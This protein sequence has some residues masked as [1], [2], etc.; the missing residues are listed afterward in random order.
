MSAWWLAEISAGGNVWRFTDGPPVVVEDSR[1]DAHR[2]ASGLGPLTLAQGET[3]VDIEF[4]RTDEILVDELEL[5][6]VVVSRWQEGTALET[7]TVFVRGRARG[8][9]YGRVGELVTLGV[10]TVAPG[11]EAPV[12]VESK[13]TDASTWPLTGSGGTL[14]QE[15]AGVPYPLLF[16]YPGYDGSAT[17]RAVVPVALAQFV[18]ATAAS[19]YAV[20]SDRNVAALTRAYLVDFAPDTPVRGWQT[21]SSI[22]DEL[23]QRLMVADFSRTP[24]NIPA[25]ATD[26]ISL[27]AGFHPTYG[28]G[29]WRSAYDVICGLLRERAPDTVDWSRM[30][31]LEE[32]LGRYQVDSWID[33]QVFPWDWIRSVLLPFLPVVERLGQGGRYLEVRRWHADASRV[34]IEVSADRGDVTR[35]SG[36]EVDSAQVVNELTVLFQP[37]GPSGAVPVASYAN[38]QGVRSIGYASPLAPTQPKV[39]PTGSDFLARRVL[40]GDRRTTDPAA[41]VEPL[42]ATS[43]RRYGT[44]NGPA[45]ELDWCWDEATAVRVARDRLEQFALPRRYVSYRVSPHVVA[46]AVVGGGLGVGA[47]DVVSLTDSEMGWDERLVIISEPPLVGPDGVSVTFLLPP[48]R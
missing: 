24:A 29:K 3:D 37:A 42:A 14:P 1:G 15:Q 41:L 45:V 44:V 48:D 12:L 28:G 34:Q 39:L 47:G 10:E 43:F 13:R 22:E 17:P 20:V 5:A 21:V 7:A 11:T 6:D 32:V 27:H 16:G 38:T 8:V 31:A 9:T 40:T 35:T 23:G 2:F 33:A 36:V 19:T 4:P 18:A 25:S 26:N 30:P 46:A